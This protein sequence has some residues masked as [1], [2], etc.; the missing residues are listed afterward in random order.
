M[1]EAGENRTW[2]RYQE[3]RSEFLHVLRWWG[4]GA[5]YVD[6]HPPLGLNTDRNLCNQWAPYIC[7]LLR[8][9]KASNAHGLVCSLQHSE[10]QP[11]S[12]PL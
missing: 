7:V 5:V 12:A 3:D 11:E 6:L 4:E 2:L 10:I 1:C 9:H 8:I